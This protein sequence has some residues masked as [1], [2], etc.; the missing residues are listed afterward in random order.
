MTFSAA[1]EAAS[2]SV[3]T[4]LILSETFLVLCAACWVLRVISCVAAPCCSTAAAI[5]VATS[6]TSPIMLLI[7]LIYVLGWVSTVA[8]A[9]CIVGMV[10]SLLLSQ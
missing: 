1:A 4:P 9:L 10:V 7:P 2:A 8:M 3:L 6:F 5:A